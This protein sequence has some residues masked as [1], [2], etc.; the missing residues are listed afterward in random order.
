MSKRKFWSLLGLCILGLAIA[1]TA[2]GM[3]V[4]HEP[5]F[6][7]QCESPPGDARKELAYAFFSNF[8]QMLADRAGQETEIW[9][10]DATQ[11]QLN[12]F[13]D[14]IFVQQGQSEAL[15][16]L[17]ISSPRITLEDPP[18][19]ADGKPMPGGYARLAFRYGSGWFS[20]VISYQLKIWLVPKEANVVA[21]EILSAR[22]GALPISKQ[23]IVNQLSEYGRKQNFKVTLYRHEGNPVAL[24]DLDG[25]QPHPTSLTTSLQ[26]S[27][28]SLMIRG[29]TL[30]HAVA[31]RR[32]VKTGKQ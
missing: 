6:Y 21:V 12:C 27:A 28:Q 3:V 31:P 4:K 2:F 30:E 32:P 14:E 10:C 13:F 20:T 26:I 22:A 15:R 5:N 23:S 25:D 17:G 16:D 18:L 8:A 19:D 11:P 9:G 7:R 24:I 1:L 29:R